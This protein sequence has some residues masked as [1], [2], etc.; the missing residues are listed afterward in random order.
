MLG[1]L[2]YLAAGFAQGWW[3]NNRLS[4][5]AVI[6]AMLFVLLSFVSYIR[7]VRI[8]EDA[9]NTNINL[10]NAYIW[11]LQP[12]EQ[13]H[14]IH[15]VPDF[16]KQLKGDLQRLELGPYR[17]R[18][19][20]RKALPIGEFKTGELLYGQRHISQK[21]T[22]T[23]DGLKAVAV[24]FVTYGKQLSGTVLWQ[25]TEVEGGKTVSSG[26][27]N[28]SHIH[29][30]ETARLKLPYLSNSKGREYQLAM[31]ATSDDAQA[32]GVAIYAAVNDSK[33]EIIVAD[34]LGLTKKE[35]LSMALRLD[36][37]K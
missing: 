1:Q 26:S 15:P 34:Q 23:E 31:S 19:Y 8:Y 24:T 4:R 12:T 28:A 17:D 16:V 22:A 3:N 32:P 36:Y 37:A 20:V 7:A 21:F 2:Y 13:D 29:D 35:N 10:A 5:I 25:V 30:W 27:L 18:Q 6:S 11:G 14:F 9:H 33:P